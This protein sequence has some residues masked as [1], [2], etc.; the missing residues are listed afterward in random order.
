VD[1]ELLSTHAKRSQNGCYTVFVND[2]DM[3][4]C[5]VTEHEKDLPDWKREETEVMP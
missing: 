4:A 5:A 2:T 3:L 1:A